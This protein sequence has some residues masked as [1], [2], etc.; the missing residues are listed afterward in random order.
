MGTNMSVARLYYSRGFSL[1]ELMVAITIGL[2]LLAGLG[3]LFIHNTNSRTEL[4]KSMQQLENGRYAID[5]LSKDIHLAG[6]YGEYYSVGAPPSGLPDPCAIDP[7]LANTNASGLQAGFFWPIQG[8]D[9][10]AA[11]PSPLSACLPDANHV[12]GTD[13]LVIRRAQ[14][15]TDTDVAHA[16]AGQI[17]LQTNT[18]SYVLGSG[19]STSVFNLKELKPNASG[20]YDTAGLRQYYVHVYFVS[21]CDVPAGGGTTCTGGADDNGAPIPTLKRLEL[22]TDGSGATAMRVVPLVE[23]IENLQLDYGFDC[24]GDGAPEV[25]D[26]AAPLSGTPPTGCSGTATDWT[27][28]MAVRVNVLARNTTF[29]VGSAPL[30]KQYN[31]GLAGNVSPTD[32]TGK[33]YGRH[34][35]TTLVRA[36]NLSGRRDQ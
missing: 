2:L 16:V 33:Y 10:P 17:Y 18:T 15:A 28:V 29:T 25:Y 19:S 3:T 9:A 21:P 27:N 26:V 23:G 11:V 13:I 36:N 34:V 24:S 5:L 6:Y 31:L 7:A 32:P 14:A 8:Y 12:A 4:E 22:A 20:T 30:A 1:V 35:Y